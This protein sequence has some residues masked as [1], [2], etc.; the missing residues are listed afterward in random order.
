MSDLSCKDTAQLLHSLPDSLILALT[1]RDLGNLGT[2]DCKL[3]SSQD[4]DKGAVPFPK[5]Y[6]FFIVRLTSDG[7]ANSSPLV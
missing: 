4:L 6:F 3:S 5:F 1:L 7:F 2:W